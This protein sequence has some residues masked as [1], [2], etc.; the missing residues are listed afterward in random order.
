MQVSL[1]FVKTS[2]GSKVVDVL[3]LVL[4]VVGVVEA[5][6][7]NACTNADLPIP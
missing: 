4:V 2:T 3:V 5:E 6:E 1:S 7:D